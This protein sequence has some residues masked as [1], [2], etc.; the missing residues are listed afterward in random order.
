MLVVDDD[1]VVCDNTCERLEE[2]G[3]IAEGVGDGRAALAK[4]VE[5]SLIHIYSDGTPYCIP[6]SPMILY[7][8]CVL[9]GKK[10]ED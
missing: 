7:F 3:M 4:V 2:L 6:I 8:H 9:V 10:S 5:L 1:V